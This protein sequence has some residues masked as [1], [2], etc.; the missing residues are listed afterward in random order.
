MHK[1]IILFRLLSELPA[2]NY[3]TVTLLLYSIMC[4]H[5]SPNF[6]EAVSLDFFAFIFFPISRLFNSVIV[7]VIFFRQGKEKSGI[8]IN[9]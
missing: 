6:K 2:G 8:S 7:K 5:S 1:F 4:M 9:E 3:S